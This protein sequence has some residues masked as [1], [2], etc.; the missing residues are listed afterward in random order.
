MDEMIEKGIKVDMILTD[1]PY[2]TT[3]CKWDSIIPLNEMWNKI[4][5]IT[6]DNGA[7][8]LFGSQPYTSLLIN[9]NLKW[10]KYCW[11][12]N[13]VRGVGHLN[14]KK[15]PLKSVE[16]VCVFYK[17]QCNYNPQMRE[18]EN[19]RKSK[20]KSTQQIYNKSQEIF[21]GKILN[22]K[23]PV[24]LLEFS[25]SD[26]KNFTLHP[27]QKPIDLCEYLIKT[28]T[29]EGDVILDFTCGSGTTLVAAKNL[30]RKCYGIELEEKYCEV[31]KNRLLE[32]IH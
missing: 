24:T 19:P 26:Q 29:N 18:R 4:K 14:A 22:K 27:T 3:Q 10:F 5:L 30:N 13:K 7:I 25:K 21:E 11:Y 8:I 20:N 2:G 15:Q 31:A 12:W 1:P 16:E 28:Y 6:K 23:Y 32:K 9:S 17:K